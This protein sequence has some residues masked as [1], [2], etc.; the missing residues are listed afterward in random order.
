M[1]GNMDINC[2]GKEYNAASPTVIE[3]VPATTNL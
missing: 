1:N 2:E 3:N